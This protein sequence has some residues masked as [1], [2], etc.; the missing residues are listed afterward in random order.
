MK[1]EKPEIIA[2]VNAASSIQ[3]SHPKV[4]ISPDADQDVTVSAYEADE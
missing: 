4:G 1:Y 2:V 3:T